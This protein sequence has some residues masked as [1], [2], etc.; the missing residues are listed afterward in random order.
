LDIRLP[1]Y[2]CLI[3][4]R[5]GMAFQSIGQM[6]LPIFALAH[7]MIRHNLKPCRILA[8]ASQ[9]SGGRLNIPDGIIHSRNQRLAEDDVRPSIHKQRGIPQDLIVALTGVLLV[10][11]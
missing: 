3:V 1:N 9:K 4:S 8:E 7:F 6:K 11:I 10:N 5:S 2:L